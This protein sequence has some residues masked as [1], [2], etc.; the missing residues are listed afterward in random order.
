MYERKKVLVAGGSGTIGIPVVRKL[1]A[2]D[3]EVTI[4]SLDQPEYVRSVVGKGPQAVR[5]D[6]TDMNVCMEVTRGQDFV[7]N[8]VG[9]KGSTGIGTRKAASY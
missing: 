7:F 6:L 5:A 2:L 4:A 8:L 1:L 9:I 3:A